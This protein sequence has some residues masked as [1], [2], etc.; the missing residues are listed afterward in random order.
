VTA[1]ELARAFR[2][3]A[4]IRHHRPADQ[5]AHLSAAVGYITIEGRVD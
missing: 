1:L 4:N 5:A 3:K 2:E